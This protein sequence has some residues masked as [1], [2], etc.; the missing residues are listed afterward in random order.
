MHNNARIWLRIGEIYQKLHFVAYQQRYPRGWLR[1]LGEF[2][3]SFSQ[4]PA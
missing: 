2:G 3:W 4:Q 1:K